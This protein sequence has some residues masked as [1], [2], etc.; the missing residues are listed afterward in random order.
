MAENKRRA[1][2]TSLLTYLLYMARTVSRV[3]VFV[4]W[5]FAPPTSCAASRR[6]IAP[7]VCYCIIRSDYKRKFS[8]EKTVLRVSCEMTP[9]WHFTD[10]QILQRV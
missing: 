7:S 2:F 4:L 3:C 6:F 5:H 9:A 1:S 8:C 10:M